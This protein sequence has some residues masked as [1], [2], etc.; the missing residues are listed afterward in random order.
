MAYTSFFRDDEILEAAVQTLAERHVPG[1]PVLVWDAGCASGEEPYSLAMMLSRRLGAFFFRQVQILAT[2]REESAFPQFEAKIR[3]GVYP[4]SD[5][6]WIPE[7]FR[8]EFVEPLPDGSGR[9]HEELRRAIAYR[10]HDLLSLEPPVQGAALVVC[11]N[12]ILHLPS[13]RRDQVVA[14]FHTALEPGGLLALDRH[15]ELPEG[16]DGLFRQVR[17]DLALFQKVEAP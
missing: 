3:A 11:K 7:T 8:A 1:R 12:V 6:Q 17:P 14:M 4:A 16:C 9:M 2:D 5:L 13:H 10:Q 15:Q